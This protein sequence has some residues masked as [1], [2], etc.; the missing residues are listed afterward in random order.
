MLDAISVLLLL[1][2]VFGWLNARFV[3][4]SPSIAMMAAGLAAGLLIQLLAPVISPDL[5]S[6][7]IAGLEALDFTS[8]LMNVAIGVLLFITARRIDLMLLDRQQYLVLALAV[9]STLINTV[10]TGA[11]TY[12]LLGWLG[13]DIPFLH[14]LLFGALI[15]PTD[16]IATI[17]ILKRAG[18]PKNLEVVIEGESLFN[19]GIGAVVFSL[20]AAVVAGGYEPT[21]IG[22]TAA[23][24]QEV[25][26]GMLL[27][28]LLGFVGAR[29]VSGSPSTLF[30]V[31]SLAV[32]FFGGYLCRQFHASYPLA[33][34]VA[35]MAMTYFSSPVRDAEIESQNDHM[36]SVIEHVLTAA[37]FLT[38]G[39]MALYPDQVSSVVAMVAIIP[40]VLISRYI[41]VA[42]PLFLRGRTDHSWEERHAFASLLTWGGLRGGIS[43]ALAL[44]LPSIA[45]K[46]MLIDL[47]YAVVVFS[48]LVQAPTLKLLFPDSLLQRIV[49]AAA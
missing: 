3:Q 25:G 15:S 4:A 16:P 8:S 32:I 17:A 47:T 24:L 31:V 22:V 45:S 36:W 40:L 26:G 9:I 42:G 23:F 29:A 33:M 2:A 46:P 35:G 11:A 20:L 12:L 28:L 30:F 48:V 43:I 7:T 27:G 34:V 13:F 6:D 49:R 21:T 37:L 5:L 39:L 10:L 1:A 19:D 18:L 14:A 41:S 38:I 44:S